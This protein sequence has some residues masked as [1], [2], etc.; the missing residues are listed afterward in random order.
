MEA[1]HA[2]AEEQL[3][4]AR[5]EYRTLHSL[6]SKLKIEHL[7]IVKQLTTEREITSALTV[8]RDQC[9]QHLQQA[10]IDF[11]ELHHMHS[12]LKS[13]SQQNDIQISVL[14]SVIDVQNQGLADVRQKYASFRG[15]TGTMEETNKQLLQDL[16]HSLMENTRQQKELLQLH[17]QEINT[18]SLANELQTCRDCLATRTHELSASKTSIARLESQIQTEEAKVCPPPLSFL[19]RPPLL[20]PLMIPI[21]G[22]FDPSHHISILS[23]IH[24][25]Y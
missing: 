19:F 21:P 23:L 16:N 25:N 5:D 3:M 12:I 4:I 18:S 20:V 14:Q 11:S 9:Q 24:H 10:L 22:N 17:Q 8:E 15:E 13:S 7:G 6:Y 2:H 1:L